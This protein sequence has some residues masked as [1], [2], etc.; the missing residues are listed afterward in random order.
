MP[1]VAPR[2]ASI[3]ASAAPMPDDA[4]V[5]STVVPSVTCTRPPSAPTISDTDVS[6]RFWL[7]RQ[8]RNV[9]PVQPKAGRSVDCGV[10]GVVGEEAGV[11]GLA[12][13]HLAP[14]GVPSGGG[15]VCG[16]S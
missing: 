13:Q 6:F 5:T 8:H 14:Q 9:S 3:G 15:R 4:P 16:G 12:A 7:Y 10:R 1:T 11:V 2:A